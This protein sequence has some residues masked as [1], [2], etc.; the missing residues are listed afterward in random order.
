MK[1]Y[2]QIW[3]VF[4]KDDFPDYDF[5]RTICK[6]EANNMKVTFSN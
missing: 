5:N 1:K 6:A 2:N 4:D 3:C